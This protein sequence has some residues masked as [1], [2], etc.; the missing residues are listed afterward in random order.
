MTTKKKLKNPIYKVG[1]L[2]IAGS[3]ETSDDILKKES[4]WKDKLGSRSFGL[5]AN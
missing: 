2:E 5:N 3:L 4:D 1:I